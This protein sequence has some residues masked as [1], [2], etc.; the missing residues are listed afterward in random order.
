MHHTQMPDV[1]NASHI[2]ADEQRFQVTIEGRFY[3]K[4]PLRESDTAQPKQTWL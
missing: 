1:F 3:R 2:T 4:N